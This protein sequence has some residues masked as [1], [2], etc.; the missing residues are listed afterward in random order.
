MFL[1]ALLPKASTL[2]SNVILEA[3]VNY[4]LLFLHV[5]GNTMLKR[6]IDDETGA[7]AIEYGLIVGL[8]SVAILLA[9]GT[10]GGQL[11]SGFEQVSEKLSPVE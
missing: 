5:I 8:I 9:V 3:V 1:P 10:I 4:G 7:T 6:F 2:P 11:K